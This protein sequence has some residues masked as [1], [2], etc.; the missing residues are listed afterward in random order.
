MSSL[1]NKIDVEI[2]H[3]E[4][5]RLSLRIDS[6]SVCFVAHSEVERDSLMSTTLALDGGNDDY[7]RS[8]ENCIY[9]NPFFL[10]DFKRVD[11]AVT[12]MRFMVLPGEMSDEASR[13]AWEALYCRE[14]GG[15]VVVDTL[16]TCGV[17]IAFEVPKGVLSFLNRTFNNPPVRHHLSAVCEHFAEKCANTGVGKEFVYFHDGRADVMVYLRGKFAFANSFVC[18]N[19]DDA[20]FYILGVWNEYALNVYNDE[21]Q[22]AGDK[23]MREVVA[24]ALRKY[25]TYVMPVIFPAAAMRIGLDA[26]KAPFDLI[27]MSLCE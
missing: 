20:T 11:I 17:K 23:R 7:L 26:M 18:E 5:W 22:I 16:L 3:P 8:L 2:H 12:S 9:D 19:A 21:L 14:Q 1:S 6:G 4:T 24:P 25:V 10:L 15:D 27:L 13:Q